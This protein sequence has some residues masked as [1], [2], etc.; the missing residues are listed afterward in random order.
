[1]RVVLDSSAL[2]AVLL[3]EPDAALFNAA[4][5]TAA[6]T[7]LSTV[8]M[9]EA[10]TVLHARKGAEAVAEFDGLITRLGTEIVAFDQ[11]QSDTAYAAYRRFGKGFNSKARLNL[12]DC[13]AYALSKTTLAPLLFKGADFH[14]TD[15][16]PALPLLV[17]DAGDRM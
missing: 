11:A 14:H 6:E 7:A 1:M 15:V 2:V 13:A 8:N 9:L 5:L 3:R 17:P 12:G 16:T 4:L 10:R